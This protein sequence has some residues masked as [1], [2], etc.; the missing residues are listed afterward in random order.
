[1]LLIEYGCI[2]GNVVNLVNL[3]EVKG[4]GARGEKADV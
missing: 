4:H 1:M 3:E 2:I